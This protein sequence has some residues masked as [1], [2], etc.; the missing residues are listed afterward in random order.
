MIDL[1][2]LKD[3]LEKQTF[4]ITLDGFDNPCFHSN[5][6]KEIVQALEEAKEIMFDIEQGK[7]PSFYI[8]EWLAKYFQ[9]TDEEK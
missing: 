2:K 3:L 1:K 5:S 8:K 4:E 7:D 6:I 9:D